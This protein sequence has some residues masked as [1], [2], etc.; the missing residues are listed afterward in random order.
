MFFREMLTILILGALPCAAKADL[1][2]LAQPQPANALWI[3]PGFYSYHF[4]REKDLNNRNFGLGAEYDFSSVSAI[5]V[6]IYDNSDRQT[7]HYAG[8]YW[9]PLLVGPARLG[10]T[11]PRSSDT[12]LL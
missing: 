8:Y 12:T 10:V 4:Q 1:F 5:T 2:M 11:R 7:T 9:R 6:G 3:N